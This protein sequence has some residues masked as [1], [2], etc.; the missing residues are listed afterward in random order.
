MWKSP[1]L[2]LR[3]SQESTTSPGKGKTVLQGQR[4]RKSL[5]VGPHVWQA[6]ST[7]SSR[8]A[9]T[10]DVRGIAGGLTLMSERCPPLAR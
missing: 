8:N 10:A 4:E 2:R 1:G 5:I 6:R 9:V 3:I 7:V